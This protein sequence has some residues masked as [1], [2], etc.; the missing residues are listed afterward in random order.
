M[1][2]TK[3]KVLVVAA[4]PDDEV[5]G[6]GATIARHADEGDEVWVLIL[7]EGVTSRIGGS[8]EEDNKELDALRGSAKKANEVL[9]VKRLILREFPDNKLDSVA[10]LDVV[11]SIESVMSEFKPNI[12]YTHHHSDVNVDHRIIAEAVESAIRPM[13]RSFVNRA[14]SFEIASSSEWNFVKSDP[15]RP[16]VFINIENYINKKIMALKCY[17]SE[18]RDFP[19]PRS[20]E[21]IEALA[22][23]RGAQ[24][25][26]RAAES[27]SLV[28]D[29][30]RRNYAK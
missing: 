9:G 25:G 29:R 30:R 24:S 21:Y 22:K 1:K 27:F 26:M 13:E 15:F 12:V 2:Q 17:G 11:Q 28:F 20:I 23:V 19:H 18:L 7:V 16:N 5:L 6:C 10:L 14:F 3:N 4:H 8:K